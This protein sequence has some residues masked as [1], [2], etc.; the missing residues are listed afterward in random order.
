MTVQI[1]KWGN[2][3]GIRISRGMLETAGMHLNEEVSVTAEKG[4]IVIEKTRTHRTLEERAAAF[5]GRLG[6]YTEFD[7]GDPAGREVW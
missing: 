1:A 3:Q 6:P 4:K 5:G 7:W 2:S